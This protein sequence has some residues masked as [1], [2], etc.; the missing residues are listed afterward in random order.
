METGELY[1]IEH[2]EDSED[3]DLLG[4]FTLSFSS[5][6]QFRWEGQ[7]EEINES[8]PL[9]SS[10]LRVSF[11]MKGEFFSELAL[12][13][14]Q[15]KTEGA[16]EVLFYNEELGQWYDVQISKEIDTDGNSF[17]RFVDVF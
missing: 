10:N 6:K 9:N 17:G 1:D 2:K 7:E 4:Y 15:N 16:E 5:E 8:F 11:I 3:D 12:I 13:K 14:L